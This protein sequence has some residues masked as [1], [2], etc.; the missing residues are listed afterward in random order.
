MS[1]QRCPNCKLWNHPNAQI[2]DCGY[3]FETLTVSAPIP[4]SSAGPLTKQKMGWRLWVQ[5]ILII[6]TIKL[7]GIL[8]GLFVWL[9]WSLIAF[10][11]KK[12]NV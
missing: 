8:G 10:L 1:D 12:Y 2:C 6:V 11:L 3:N 5:V 4:G 9:I 7:F